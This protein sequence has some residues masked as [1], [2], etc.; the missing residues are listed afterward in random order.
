MPPSR[1]APPAEALE[2][3]RGRKPLSELDA[4]RVVASWYLGLWREVLTPRWLH[5]WLG[6]RHTAAESYAHFPIL[7]AWQVPSRL[8]DDITRARRAAQAPPEPPP[9]ER[10]RALPPFTGMS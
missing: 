10:E 9:P 3:L 2:R 7:Y 8:A 6:V 4:G 1:L 5:G